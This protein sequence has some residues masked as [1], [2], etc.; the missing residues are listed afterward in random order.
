MSHEAVFRLL[1]D[2]IGDAEVSHLRGL[3]ACLD[4]S[5]LGRDRCYRRI[6][7]TTVEIPPPCESCNL[8]ETALTDDDLAT[9]ASLPELTVLNLFGTKITDA[10]LGILEQM[11]PLR[12]VYLWRSSV[13]PA[14][15]ARL[16][17]ARPDLLVDIGVDIGVTSE[18]EKEVGQE[19]QDEKEVGEAK[20]ETKE[21]ESN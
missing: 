21:Q 6:D 17:L 3:V 1:K 19:S 16:S 11:G 13:T 15:A 12:R 9:L 10:G 20:E 18:P 7:F 8:S 4:S 2:Q 14:G 5:R